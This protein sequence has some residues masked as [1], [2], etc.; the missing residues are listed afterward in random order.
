MQKLHREWFVPAFYMN[1]R[2]KRPTNVLIDPV[3]ALN[4]RVLQ[5]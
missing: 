5:L 4:C 1:R 3:D 2:L